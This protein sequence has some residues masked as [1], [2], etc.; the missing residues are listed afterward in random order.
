MTKMNKLE[1]WLNIAESDVLP[2]SDRLEFCI[3]KIK[4]MHAHVQT[5]LEGHRKTVNCKADRVL[6][7]EFGVTS[8]C[9][10]AISR[11]REE[12]VNEPVL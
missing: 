6:W 9:G 5:H 1:Q 11:N 2:V 12:E 10:V 8:D 3:Q 7:L 4:E